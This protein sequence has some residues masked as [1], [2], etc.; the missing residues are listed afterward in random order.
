M[1][2]KIFYLAFILSGLCF[3]QNQIMI[4]FVKNSKWGFSDVNKKILITPQYD[5]VSF[6]EKVMVNRKEISFA[7]AY[8]NKRIGII[9]SQ[10][11]SLLPLRYLNLEKISDLGYFI[12]KNEQNK[13]GIISLSTPVLPF[14]YDSIS[15]QMDNAFLIKKNNKI[16]IA[17][18]QAKIVIPVIYDQINF[19][20]EDEEKH[21]YRWR[22]SNE[23][24]TQYVYTPVQ[25]NL[26]VS[27]R[28]EAME[29]I[30][31]TEIIAD[32]HSSSNKQFK[33]FDEKI[34]INYQYKSFIT[35]KNNLYGFINEN[36]NIGFLPKFEKLEFLTSDLDRN[37]KI[38]YFLTFEKDEKKGLTNQTGEVLLPAKYDEI[39]IRLKFIQT[40]LDDKKGIYFISSNRFIDPKFVEVKEY[41]DLNEAFI[42]VR[43]SE[44]HKK[45]FYVG[46]NGNAFTE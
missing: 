24:I 11:K 18:A 6:F 46:E 35:R 7:F 29:D 41:N 45:Y 5:S 14:E 42:V 32:S 2:I 13:F 31:S 12:A 34:P 30:Q 19:M 17:D 9:D 22:V 4:P 40:K 21:M 20:D 36:S 44:D 3:G 16:G 28:V 25:E 33:D 15:S 43:V 37:H 26:N 1:K 8:M 39:E 27:Y 23:K 10:N 38:N